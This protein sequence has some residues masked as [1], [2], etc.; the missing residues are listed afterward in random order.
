MVRVLC[1]VLATA[2]CMT[3]NVTTNNAFSLQLFTEFTPRGSFYP[4]IKQTKV[5]IW[6]DSLRFPNIPSL[7]STFYC[8]ALVYT[9]PGWWVIEA[10]TFGGFSLR[11][12]R[13]FFIV[14]V[15]VYCWMVIPF[16]HKDKSS[17]SCATQV[18]PMHFFSAILFLG[19]AELGGWASCNTHS[20]SGQC[21]TLHCGG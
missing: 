19:F 18:F 5:L 20:P 11:H 6:L 14:C 12:S 4:R 15:G 13:Y 8:L 9:S 21:S 2:P 16:A 10:C 17:T 7:L 3:S 1:P